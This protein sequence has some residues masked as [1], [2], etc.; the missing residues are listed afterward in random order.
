MHFRGRGLLSMEN[1]GASLILLESGG[2]C[3]I[4]FEIAPIDYQSVASIKDSASPRNLR[5]LQK[6]L[7]SPDYCFS[8]VADTSV[9]NA[10][11]VKITAS[12]DWIAKIRSQ[13]Q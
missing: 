9:P 5:H 1:S 6:V 4:V 13:L 2:L 7:K 10:R 12:G 8:I 11:V 3:P